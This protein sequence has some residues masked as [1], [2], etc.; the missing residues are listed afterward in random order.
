MTLTGNLDEEIVYAVE[1][2]W[3]D[4]AVHH[5]LT[6]ERTYDWVVRSV[7]FDPMKYGGNPRVFGAQEWSYELV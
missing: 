1:R 4:Q 6:R 2:R 7:P 5:M 3:M